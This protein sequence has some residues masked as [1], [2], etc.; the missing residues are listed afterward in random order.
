MQY[1]F[2]CLLAFGNIHDSTLIVRDIPLGITF[3]QPSASL[4]IPIALLYLS[5]PFSIFI[6]LLYLVMDLMQA[7]KAR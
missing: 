2:F 1:F 4:N 7:R 5:F 6:M 3:D